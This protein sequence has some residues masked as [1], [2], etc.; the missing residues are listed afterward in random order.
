MSE[1]FIFGLS[2]NKEWMNGNNISHYH[3]GTYT[4]ESILKENPTYDRNKLKLVNKYCITI[5]SQEAQ[6]DNITNM[7]LDKTFLKFLSYVSG[8]SLKKIKII[9]MTQ[10]PYLELVT[11][12]GFGICLYNYIKN[13]PN[14]AISITY[15][16]IFRENKN[17]IKLM[18]ESL[19]KYKMVNC[20]SLTRYELETPITNK[21]K[22]LIRWIS[23]TNHHTD[24]RKCDI[25]E[26]SRIM[27]IGSSNNL[28]LNDVFDMI[29]KCAD[30]I[31]EF[32]KDVVKLV[33]EFCTYDM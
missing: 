31:P 2:Q 3:E 23:P 7:K 14:W 16:D 33:D 18:T 17:M 1:K 8:I 24:D 6:T 26:V 29:I 11:S 27:I 12:H 4:F 5:D 9:N 20:V 10:I 25:A 15:C 30:N 22:L 28:D 19:E 13:N 32:C 21:Y